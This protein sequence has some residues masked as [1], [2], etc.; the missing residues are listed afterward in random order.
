M[1][2]TKLERRE[3]VKKVNHSDSEELST[4]DSSTTEEED[5]SQ[6]HTSESVNRI[7][8]IRPKVGNPK[9]EHLTIKA[10]RRR[11]RLNGHKIAAIL[12][13]GSPITILPKKYKPEMKPTRVIKRT[14]NRKFV[15][16]SGRPLTIHNRYKI[17]T[18]LN[19]T[20]KEVIWWEIDAITKLIMGMDN[21]ISSD[22]N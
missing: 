7:V 11:I 20:S 15:D 6:S 14:S 13:T 16:V 4:E 1:R 17:T 10:N 21:L 5:A 18:E 19:G 22:S 2:K 12:D 8:E 3:K 9:P